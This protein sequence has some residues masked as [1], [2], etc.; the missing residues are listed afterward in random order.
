M[1]KLLRFSDTDHLLLVS[2]HHIIC[3]GISLG[4]LMRDMIRFY[5]AELTHSEPDLPQLPIQFADFAVWQEEWLQSAE[6]ARSLNFWKQSLGNDFPRLNLPRDPDALTQN[7][8][9]STGD[10]ETL[11]IPLALQT[12]SNAF[13]KREN[14]TLNILLFS[15]FAALLRRL[16]GQLDLV[17][18]SPCA[19]RTEDTQELIG[20]L[21]NI[22]VMR[23]RLAPEETFHQLLKRVQDWTLGAYENQDLP[24]E[25]L[26]HDPYFSNGTAIASKCPFSSSTRSPSCRPTR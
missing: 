3:D 22:Q 25:A 14:V 17:I 10:I 9:E 16:T 13:C 7:E 5:E 26:V 15:V 23:L 18:G 20:L 19:N 2:M 8:E 4:V 12:L 6:P 21:M 11:Q 1:L 24:F